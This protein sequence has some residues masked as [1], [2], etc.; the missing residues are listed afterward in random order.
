[1]STMGQVKQTIPLAGCLGQPILIRTQN[2]NKTPGM[3]SVKLIILIE[4]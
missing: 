2:N 3:K 1:M 4:K